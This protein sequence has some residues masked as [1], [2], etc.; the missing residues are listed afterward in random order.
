MGFKFIELIIESKPLEWSFDRGIYL[1]HHTILLKAHLRKHQLFGIEAPWPCNKFS[2]KKQICHWRLRI[3][4]RDLD[5]KIY[6]SSKYKLIIED[7]IKKIISTNVFPKVPLLFQT[8][9][10]YMVE[11]YKKE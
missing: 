7:N 10:S 6:S 8:H 3:F 9:F 11:K 2:L 5:P 4:A 1:A